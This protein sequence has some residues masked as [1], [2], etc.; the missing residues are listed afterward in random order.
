MA[1]LLQKLV[2]RAPPFNSLRL[3]TSIDIP[4]LPC[5]STVLHSL[6]RESDHGTGRSRHSGLPLDWGGAD[7]PCSMQHAHLIFP[8]FLHVQHLEP[9]HQHCGVD[10]D[11]ECDEGSAV[12]DRTLWADSVKKKRKR[13]MNKHKLRKL[14]RQLRRKTKT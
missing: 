7:H 8:T 12:D 2:K 4:Q 11:G 14:R 10:G 3:L 5:S 1:T 13:K 9:I 6:R